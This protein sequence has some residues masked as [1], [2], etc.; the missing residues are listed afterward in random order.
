[1][2]VAE[3]SQKF[4]LNR[5][6]LSGAVLGTLLAAQ[7]TASAATSVFDGANR[8]VSTTEGS[9]TVTYAYDGLGNLAKR[10]VNGACTDLVLDDSSALAQV[11][12]EAPVG[13]AT[14]TTYAYG[15][16][17]VAAQRGAAPLYPVTDSL[18]S[19][20]GLADAVGT[21]AGRHAT[22]AFGA[23]RSRT[24]V[25]SALGYTGELSGAEDGKI[26][27][28][29]RS[30]DPKTGRFDQRDTFEGFAE[31][32]M[33]LNRYSYAENNA[34]NLTDP[35]GHF[36]PAIAVGGLIV[37]LLTGFATDMVFPSPV[38]NGKISVSR[39]D[40][41]AERDYETK[42][43]LWDLGTFLWSSRRAF[44]R[45][46]SV[47]SNM[48]SPSPGDVP[49]TYGQNVVPTKIGKG[50]VK[51]VFREG[52]TVIYKPRPG[53]D[54]YFSDEVSA[55]RDL[56]GLGMPHVQDMTPINH[57]SL[58]KG[59]SAPFFNKSGG[60]EG[61]LGSPEALNRALR[62]MA[63]LSPEASARARQSFGQIA[64]WAQANGIGVRDFGFMVSQSGQ[65]VVHDVMKVLGKGAETRQFVEALETLA[66]RR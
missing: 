9:T 39:E 15:P 24:G 2:R 4:V 56:K 17:G 60:L 51:D 66:G 57:P 25:S 32:G 27:L 42:K 3:L 61:K 43:N 22:D 10:C 54:D 12:G 21:I 7:G 16:A 14:P 18:G 53:A 44:G 58:G 50:G 63:N 59:Y 28:R 29:A 23:T 46:G 64:D 11:V 38:A 33:S 20:R 13:A 31:R 37:G 55:L 30:Y 1:M 35:S 52:D 62:N 40:C 5:L 19:V 47:K 48:S 36:I 26:W 65:V 41:A 8:L 49:P 34:A 45:A 6:A